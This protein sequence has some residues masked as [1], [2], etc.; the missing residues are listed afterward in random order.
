MSAEENKTISHRFMEE[1]VQGRA[2]RSVCFALAVAMSAVVWIAGEANAGHG[3]KHGPTFQ[4]QCNAMQPFLFD[5]IKPPPHHLHAPYGNTAIDSDSTFGTL[6]TNAETTCRSNREWHNSVYWNPV[7]QE[8]GER[9]TPVQVKAYYTALGDQSKVRNMPPGAEMIG[10]VARYRCG[11]GDESRSS[12]R[13]IY[14]CEQDKFEITV[15]FPSCWD[16][17]GKTYEHFRYPD[18]TK[19]PLGTVKIPRLRLSTIHDAADD[20]LDE[21]LRVSAGAG[22]WAG[23]TSFHADA[24]FVDTW[25]GDT[26]SA[27]SEFNALVERCI[28]QVGD[29]EARPS[30]CG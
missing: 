20:R 7:V 23:P 24:M 13:P 15:F 27:M 16:H 26:N 19:C 11:L 14:G 2:F 4:I 28:R 17:D 30:G 25:P 12:V 10:N 5:A 22:E 9:M 8:G 18:G 1:R 6:A 3:G 21:P 29:S